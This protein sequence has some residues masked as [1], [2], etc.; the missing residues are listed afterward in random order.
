MIAPGIHDTPEAGK[1]I[2]Q[3][4]RACRDDALGQRLHTLT[5]EPGDAPDLEPL[6]S[7]VV[8]GLN[9]G[10]DGRLAG[11]ATSGLSAGPLATQIGIVQ[12]DTPVQPILV[13]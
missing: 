4:G 2:G 10:N 11:A 6:G 5:L 1:A 13:A 9:G 12:L 8:R 3:N 7:T